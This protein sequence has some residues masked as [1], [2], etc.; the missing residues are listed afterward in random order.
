[1]FL[2][3]AYALKDPLHTT[4]E[5]A[6]QVRCFKFSYFYRD[7]LENMLLEKKINRSS[8]FDIN[9]FGTQSIYGTFSTVH[10]FFLTLLQ[11]KKKN[12][13]HTFS[14]SASDRQ[15]E[16]QNHLSCR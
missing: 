15:A 16:Q 2:A 14:E 7:I 8:G 10:T 6:K 13:I 11:G 4:E 12:P 5:P 9:L 3:D 1:M